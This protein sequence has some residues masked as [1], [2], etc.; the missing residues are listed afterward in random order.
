MGL[1]I[2]YLLKIFLLKIGLISVEEAE[3]LVLKLNSRLGRG[4]GEDDVKAFF[5]TLD[6]SNDGSL[7]LEKFRLAFLNLAV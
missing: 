7:N 1:N 5:S 6:Y 3:K 4:Y 2:I